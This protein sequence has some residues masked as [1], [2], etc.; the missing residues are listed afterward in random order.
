MS[1]NTKLNHQFLQE[2]FHKPKFK[3]LKR[4]FTDFELSLVLPIGKYIQGISL[5][6]ELIASH[7]IFINQQKTIFVTSNGVVGKIKKIEKN[8]LRKSY[9]ICK[10]VIP[11]TR[12][13]MELLNRGRY[14]QYLDSTQDQRFKQQQKQK[15]KKNLNKNKNKKNKKKKKKNKKKN[16]DQNS[17]DFDFRNKILNI[18]TRNFD[19]IKKEIKVYS[20]KFPICYKDCP[21]LAFVQ[22]KKR[23]CQME[24]EREKEKEKLMKK[25]KSKNKNKNNIGSLTSLQQQPQLSKER[26]N[27]FLK[28]FG[29]LDKDPQNFEFTQQFLMC[30]QFYG[31]KIKISKFVQYFISEYSDSE[32]CGKFVQG[33]IKQLVKQYLQH[34][35]YQEVITMPKFESKIW[36]YDFFEN[37]I[38][39]IIYDKAILLLKKS[40]KTDKEHNFIQSRNRLRFVELRHLEQDPT[41]IDPEVISNV[42]KILTQINLVRS[43][44]EK[45]QMI[46]ACSH[47]INKMLSDDFIPTFIYI[48]IYS[49]IPNLILNVEYINNF[50][51]SENLSMTENGF[52]F[53]T[54]VSGIKYIENIKETSLTIDPL[55]FHQKINQKNHNHKNYDIKKRIE[56]EI[57]IYENSKEKVEKK[58]NN[59]NMKIKRRNTVQVKHSKNNKNT[60]FENN[61]KNSNIKIKKINDNKPKTNPNPNPNPINNNMQKKNPKSKTFL[62]EKFASD[63]QFD[64]F[65]KFDVKNE[66]KKNIFESSPINNRK[67]ENLWD[68]KNSDLNIK[69]KSQDQ[70]PFQNFNTSNKT[71]MDFGKFKTINPNLLKLDQINEMFNMYPN[72]LYLYFEKLKDFEN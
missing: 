39:N 10:N 9:L 23:Q 38:L 52:Y 27:E 25:N 64:L 40:W 59:I 7:L 44:L 69:Q 51:S 47:E 56:M 17:T 65:G 13:I 21:W 11:A 20:I 2:L 34:P 14:E 36:I 72:L 29:K 6:F 45:L 71:T 1:Q 12:C 35:I 58:I 48:L 41:S 43:P 15:Q 46:S 31:L 5:T 22:K 66:K 67:N 24:K 53:T 60:S 70:D 32:N 68:S 63:E 33:F 49:D 61:G 50:R 28:T 19:L 37:Y 30:E 54:I 55:T 26:K 16:Q 8:N 42:M 62:L 57:Q 3:D 18:E 4:K